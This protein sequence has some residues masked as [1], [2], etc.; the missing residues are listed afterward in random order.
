MEHYYFITMGVTYNIELYL[1]YIFHFTMLKDEGKK[2]YRVVLYLM[3]F[4]CYRHRNIN[5]KCI[6]IY[7]IN[8]STHRILIRFSIFIG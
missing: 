1:F 4:Q 2:V 6:I 7:E 5:K 3:Y 8:I